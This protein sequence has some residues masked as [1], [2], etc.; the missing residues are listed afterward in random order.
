[1][2]RVNIS[3]LKKCD[4]AAYQVNSGD[5]KGRGS[6]TRQGFWPAP[7]FCRSSDRKRS[8]ERGRGPVRRLKVELFI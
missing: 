3:G 6:L 4:N 2:R 5:G 1:M 7:D 8:D